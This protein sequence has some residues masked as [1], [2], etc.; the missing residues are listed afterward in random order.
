MGRQCGRYR[1]KP[2]T[3]VA[4]VSIDLLN[5]QYQSDA[6]AVTRLQATVRYDEA[7]AD[8]MI[9]LAKAQAISRQPAR[10]EAVSTRD[11]DRAQLKE[12]IADA[13]KSKYSLDHGQIRAPFPGRVAQRLINPGEYATRRKG[14][15]QDSSISITSRSA[16]P[17]PISAARYLKPG[18][19]LTMGIENKSVVGS[20]RAAVPVGDREQQDDRSAYSDQR[21]GRCRGRCC[22]RAD[23]LRRRHARVLAVPRDALVLREDT[24]Y[25]FRLAKDN[26]VAR[27]AVETGTEDGPLVEIKGDIQA[28]DLVATRGVERL[29]DGEA[30]RAT[31]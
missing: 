17:A 3:P 26:T 19:R 18:T 21:R 25:V 8:R 1:K 20:I 28:G 23:P 7:Q 14:Y 4:T 15:R 5:D 10:Y 11:A 27:I 31:P 24:T 22:P 2:A 29:E 6:A 13:A 30:V 9:K 16:R 12:A